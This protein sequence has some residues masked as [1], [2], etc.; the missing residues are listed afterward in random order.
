MEAILVH[1]VEVRD[2]DVKGSGVTTRSRH[3]LQADID[4]E[5]VL[6]E[7]VVADVGEA[8]DRLGGE[9]EVSR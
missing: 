9:V 2:V 8:E 1:K 7:K 3:L 6:P 4:E 5:D